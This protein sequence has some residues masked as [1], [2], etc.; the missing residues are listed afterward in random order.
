MEPLYYNAGEIYNHMFD[1]VKGKTVLFVSHRMACTRFC[2]RVIVFDKGKIVEDGSHDELIKQNGQ[3]SLMW[4]AQA[5]YY[6]RGEE[7]GEMDNVLFS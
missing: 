1:Y 4:N 5:K 3:Y 7:N 2:K 6:E